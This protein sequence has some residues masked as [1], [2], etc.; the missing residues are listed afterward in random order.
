METTIFFGD[1][2]LGFR[3]PKVCRRMAL[4]AVI[5]GLGPLFNMLLGF[6]C[7]AGTLVRSGILRAPKF[8]LGTC[9]RGHIILPHPPRNPERNISTPLHCS[10]RNFL[11][12]NCRLMHPSVGSWRQSR[13][14]RHLADCE[15]PSA[16]WHP[17]EAVAVGRADR[18]KACAQQGPQ[19]PVGLLARGSQP[20]HL[21]RWQWAR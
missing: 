2:V 4:M 6:R 21:S 3:T 19:L 15:E 13:Q 16:Y 5:M 8:S 1:W 12:L 14:L 10:Y 20:R 11:P 17:E 18:A 9:L 7:W